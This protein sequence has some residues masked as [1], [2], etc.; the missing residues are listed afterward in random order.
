[1]RFIISFYPTYAHWIVDHS[2]HRRNRL[3]THLPR[4]RRFHLTTTKGQEAQSQSETKTLEYDPTTFL[5]HG[6]SPWKVSAHVSASGGV[7]NAVVNAAMI[8]YVRP[9]SSVDRHS[10]LSF[11]SSTLSRL[12]FALLCPRFRPCLRGVCPCDVASTFSFVYAFLVSLALGFANPLLVE[13]TPS[14]SFSNPNAN[15][16]LLI[17]Q[18]R[19]P[20]SS[21][22]V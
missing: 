4:R 15:G 14:P 13:S 18:T 1:V 2:V 7:E 20:R 9:P 21:S 3:P 12:P 19:L 8:E 16:S 11:H 6:K 17:F 10:P 5:P 22:K